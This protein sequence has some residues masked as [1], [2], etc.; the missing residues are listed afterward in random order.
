MS[1]LFGNNISQTYQGLIKL[2]D[3]TT[4][5]TSVTQSLQDGL[6]NNIPIQVSNNTVNISGSFLVNG[7][8]ISVDTGSLVT[9]SS[10]NAYTSSV[11]TQLAG[12]DI[13]TGSLQNQING[14]ATTGSL[15]SLSSSIAT[16]DLGQN[17]RLGSLESKTG[18]YATTGSNQFNGNQSITGSLRA[19]ST[20]TSLDGFVG[21][22]LQ[23][24]INLSVIGNEIV[25]IK[26]S[27]TNNNGKVRLYS[28]GNYPFK[29]EVSG[30]LNV[31]DGITGS[32][33]GT[34]SYATQAL[35]ASY[36][37]DNSNRNGLI[38]TGSIGG[39]QSITGSL[40][41]SGTLTAT[42]ASITY[43]ETV[44]ETASIIYSSGS[45]QFGDA[46]DDTQTLWGTVNLP[47]GPLTITGSLHSSN[48][49]GTGSLFLQPNQSDARL[50]EIYN[51]SPTDTHITASG[52]Q[53]FLG[54]DTTYVKVDNYGSTDR[55]DI[56]AVNGV[57]V[58]SSLEVTGSIFVTD[59]NTNFNRITLDDNAIINTELSVFGKSG[60]AR[61]AAFFE[62]K[63]ADSSSVPNFNVNAGTAS[64]FINLEDAIS[65]SIINTNNKLNINSYDQLGLYGLNGTQVS[66]S[67]LVSG[68]LE[69]TGSINATNDINSNHNINVL[70]VTPSLNF[71]AN[72]DYSG[73]QYGGATAYYDSGSYPTDTY[74]GFTVTDTNTYQTAISIAAN[75]Y[76]PQYGG[77]IVGSIAGGALYNGSDAAIILPFS[78]AIVEIVKPLKL[79]AGLTVTGGINYASGSNTTIGTV[80]LNG[81]SPASASISNSL[82]TTASLIFLTK[83]TNNHTNAGPVNVSSKGAGTFTIT[84]NHN[85]DTDIVAYQIINPA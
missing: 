66:G 25:D 78:D 74:I 70:G 44:Y 61:D 23:S 51:T 80:A 73:S 53:L 12:L 42:S 13:E 79:D 11:N 81:G 76:T 41:I 20:V 10:F 1:T 84:S 37:P 67:L 8:P 29:V 46:S 5:V 49:I 62:V 75:T 72:L 31:R 22:Y 68:S 43:L 52:G 24:N 55:I 47:T 26:T 21:P 58:S 38:N 56:V 35:S 45:N 39:T 28:S 65:G 50:V 7:Q 63:Y 83:Q 40:D 77:Q 2:T 17:N 64:I 71:M 30:S 85:N 33:Q 4:G 69:I 59:P 9:T 14:L 19:S 54:D 16:T 3:S 15:T 48:I 18:S 60:S 27:T 82:V 32:L 34:A 6:G 36:A 57:Y